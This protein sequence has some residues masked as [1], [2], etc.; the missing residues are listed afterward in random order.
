MFPDEVE[1]YVVISVCLL[2]KSYIY[3]HCSIL[4]H[5]R[6]PYLCSAITRAPSSVRMFRVFGLNAVSFVPQ[7]KGGES[8]LSRE[9]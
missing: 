8:P 9:L 5:M 3:T 1:G 2:L 6:L 7:S 4:F